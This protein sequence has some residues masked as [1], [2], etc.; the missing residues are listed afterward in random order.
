MALRDRISRLRRL[1]SSVMHYGSP[2]TLAAEH[3][4]LGVF[5]EPLDVSPEWQGEV[6][7]AMQDTRGGTV[8]RSSTAPALAE[9]APVVGAEAGTGSLGERVRRLRDLHGISLVPADTELNLSGRMGQPLQSLQPLPGNVVVDGDRWTQAVEQGEVVDTGLR[10]REGAQLSVHQSGAIVLHDQH[11]AIVLGRIEHHALQVRPADMKRR[12]LNSIAND[13]FDRLRVKQGDV[14]SNAW[15]QNQH[16]GHRPTQ[17]VTEDDLPNVLL[18]HVERDGV[19]VGLVGYDETSKTAFYWDRQLQQRTDFMPID[20]SPAMGDAA[21]VSHPIYDMVANDFGI[22][23]RDPTAPIPYERVQNL[24]TLSNPNG[25][26]RLEISP[27]L[28]AAR[29]SIGDG[30]TDRAYLD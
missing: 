28:A 19:N 25:L 4:G 1:V 26:Q 24:M 22:D 17:G 10:T 16:W 8:Y 3:H 5:D 23:D 29:E 14:P 2:E 6:V 7:P 13:A 12:Q 18:N 27:A 30:G 9:T 11:V 15:L 20:M 21:N